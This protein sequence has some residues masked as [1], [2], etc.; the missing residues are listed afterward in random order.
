MLPPHS[1]GGKFQKV[2][3]T[4]LH[5]SP[6]GQLSIAIGEVPLTLHF[7]EETLRRQASRRY[8]RFRAAQADGLT[9]F[10]ASERVATDRAAEFAYTVGDASLTL[11]S[12]TAQFCGV[13]HE[14]ALDS[15][16][17]ILLSVMLLPRR[18]F[19]LHAATVVRDD[20]AYIFAGRS[21]AGKSTVATLSPSGGVLTDEISLLRFSGGA[22]QAHGTPFWGEF[23]AAGSNRHVPVAGIYAL[24][25]APEDRL[26][27]LS[28][29]QALRALL[30]NVLF[31][32]SSNRQ[33]QHL[34]QLLAEASEQIPIYRLYFRRHAR[35]WE[36][37]AA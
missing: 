32:E 18:G 2:D 10:L 23:R 9:V 8:A 1:S 4:A 34:L 24:A 7:H 20:R 22:W 30:P 3:N 6:A 28:I 36:V 12:A 35:F 29:K 26:E 21:G 33:T 15:L 14:F 11:D 13:R 31:F 16:L 19:L 37:I 25:Q 5:W 17:R 27:R